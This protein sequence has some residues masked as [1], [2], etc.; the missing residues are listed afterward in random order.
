MSCRLNFKVPEIKNQAEKIE[1]I[2]HICQ[3]DYMLFILRDNNLI[4]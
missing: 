1:K 2:N 3:I 4:Q